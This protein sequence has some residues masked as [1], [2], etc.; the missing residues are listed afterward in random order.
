MDVSTAIGWVETSLAC[1]TVGLVTVRMSIEYFTEPGSTIYQDLRR[2][3]MSTTR[4]LVSYSAR[5]DA[6][7]L[8]AFSPPLPR[9]PSLGRTQ[10]LKRIHC[11]QRLNQGVRWADIHARSD[12]PQLFARHV[13][14]FVICAFGRVPE[15]A[16]DCSLN[17]DVVRIES[18][19]ALQ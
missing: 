5:Q 2:R 12:Q 17:P 4:G 15:E 1:K 18:M 14:D 19:D 9:N 16:I 6:T 3:F 7:A 10:L 13:V 8:G 11:C